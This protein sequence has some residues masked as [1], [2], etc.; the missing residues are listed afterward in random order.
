VILKRKAVPITLTF[1][2]LGYA[3]TAVYYSHLI[4]WGF[5]FPNRCPVSADILSL[6]SPTR[7][8]IARTVALGA[9]NAA[10]LAAID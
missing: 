5:D 9:I 8:F 6:G 7:E 10:M 3:G 2:V 4:V 1:I